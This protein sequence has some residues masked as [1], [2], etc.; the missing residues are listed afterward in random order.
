MRNPEDFDAFDA[1]QQWVEKGK[2]PDQI[3]YSHR[4]GGGGAAGMG[5]PGEVYRKR[6]SCAYPKQAKYKGSGDINDAANFTCVNPGK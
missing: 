3:I 6:P 1:I 4:K 2:A 5:T